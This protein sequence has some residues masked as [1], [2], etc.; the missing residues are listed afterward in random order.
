M[1]SQNR[2]ELKRKER[3]IQKENKEDL[4][5]ESLEQFRN[6]LGILSKKGIRDYGREI[7]ETDIAGQ[8]SPESLDV[9]FKK[10]F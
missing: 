2:S 10:K 9:E 4:E 1:L 7:S 8:I 5:K 6:T 3:K